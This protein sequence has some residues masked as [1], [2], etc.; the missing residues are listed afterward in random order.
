MPIFV[1]PNCRKSRGSATL[2]A[3]AAGTDSA[4]SG[5]I[6]VTATAGSIINVSST[7]GVVSPD[8]SIYEYR[9]V[10]GA[11][12][13]KPVG[14][15]VAKSGVLN[16]TRWLAQQDAV[17]AN[18]SPPG[19]QFGQATQPPAVLP[20]ALPAEAPAWLRADHA[21]QSAAALFYAGQ[22]EAARQRFGTGVHHGYRNARVGEAHGDAAP[23]GTGADHGGWGNEWER[24]RIDF[25]VRHL[26]KETN[27][28]VI[29]LDKLTLGPVLKMDPKT[30]KFIGNAEAD[31]QLTRDYRKP[32]VVPAI[33]A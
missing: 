17:F 16:F 18:C 26:L 30:E 15:S 24:K 33:S 6:T 25:F 2:T 28:K 5:N 9:R 19:I 29:N 3:S 4:T 32:F 31:K 21:Y 14:Y 7:Y 8:Q 11:T 10:G 13:Y 12:Y 20:P 22:Y 1:S 27:C 23:H